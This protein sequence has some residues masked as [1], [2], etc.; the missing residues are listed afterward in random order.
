MIIS[1]K[2]KQIYIENRLVVVKGKEGRL[3]NLGLAGENY[4][5]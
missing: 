3:G 4:C 2:K 1:T 5:I